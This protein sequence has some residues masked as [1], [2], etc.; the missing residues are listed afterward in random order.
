LIDEKKKIDI[1]VDFGQHKN[2]YN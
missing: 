1:K 2:L